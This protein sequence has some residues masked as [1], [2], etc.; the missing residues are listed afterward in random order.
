[1]LLVKA[2]HTA[3]LIVTFL[4]PPDACYTSTFFIKEAGSA[5]TFSTLFYEAF[6]GITSDTSLGIVAL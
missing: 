4:A 5:Y 2:S 3:L 1:M 6:G